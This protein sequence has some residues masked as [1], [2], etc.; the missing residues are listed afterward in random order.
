M[1][2]KKKRVQGKRPIT[3]KQKKFCKALLSGVE[4]KNEAVRVAG[5]DSKHPGTIAQGLMKS[6]TVRAYLSKAFEKV[7][8]TDD[9]TA[10]KM[11]EGMEAMTPPKKDGGKRY[12]DYFVRKQYLDVYYRIKGA[13]APEQSEHVE[14]VIVLQFTPQFVKG[15]VDSGKVTEEEVGVIEAE[16]IRED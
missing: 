3:D 12:E 2:E 16:I 10:Q 4:S 6:E 15:L 5:Y 14:K 9:Y 8:I 7:G 11:K 1:V 13:Y